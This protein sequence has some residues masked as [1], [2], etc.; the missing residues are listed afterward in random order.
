MIDKYKVIFSKAT[1]EHAGQADKGGKRR[2][3]QD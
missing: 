3:F 1:S 2:I